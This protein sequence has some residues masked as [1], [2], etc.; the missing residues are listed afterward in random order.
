MTNKVN[1]PATVGGDVKAAHASL[2]FYHPD[3]DPDSI[4][5][6]LGCTPSLCYRAG[7][8]ISPRVA[9]TRK[10]GMWS[11]ASDLT[12]DRPLSEHLRRV[13]SLVSS[14][15]TKWAELTRRYSAD[16][17]CAIDISRDNSGASIPA[18]V[19]EEVGARGL[20]IELDFYV[21]E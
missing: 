4:T 7:D 17:Y 16:I 12:R 3:L 5:A 1:D 6:Y 2:R 21:G 13:L 11:V 9:A 10:N 8:Q 15:L 19:I 20:S 14:D 18:D